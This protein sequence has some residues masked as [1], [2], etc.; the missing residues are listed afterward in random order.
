MSL[1]ITNPVYV[2]A[3]A[4]PI[5]APKANS[6][7]TKSDRFLPYL[8]DAMPHMTPPIIVPGEKN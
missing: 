8:S 6:E 2:G 3:N 1:K 5:P 7:T 4:A